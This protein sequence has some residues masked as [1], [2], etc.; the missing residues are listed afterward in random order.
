M[1][2]HIYRLTKAGKTVAGKVSLNGRNKFLDYLYRQ[3][4]RTASDEDMEGWF[5]MSKIEIRMAMRKL[6]R[7]V[8]DMT[9]DDGGI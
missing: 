7:L 5:G 3:R 6:G 2:I 8:E 4:N 1:S 9:R